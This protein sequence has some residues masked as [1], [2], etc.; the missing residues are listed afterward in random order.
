MELTGL[1]ADPAH[2][3]HSL[4]PLLKDPEGEWPHLARTSFGPGNY[5]IVSERYRFIQYNDGSEELYDHS[6]ND[7]AISVQAL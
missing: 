5:A 7:F 1:E 4:A 3:G 6:S 2:E